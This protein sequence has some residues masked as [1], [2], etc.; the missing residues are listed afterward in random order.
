MTRPL[1]APFQRIQMT[2][3]AYNQALLEMASQ[4]LA[5]LERTAQK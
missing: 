3:P 2:L 5:E 4:S 1:A